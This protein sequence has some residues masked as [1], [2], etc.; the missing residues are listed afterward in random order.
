MLKLAIN[1][2]NDQ[3]SSELMSEDIWCM[4]SMCRVINVYIEKEHK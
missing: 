3:L 1:K 4:C 2:D